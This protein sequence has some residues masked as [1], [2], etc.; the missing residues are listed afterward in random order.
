MIKKTCTIVFLLG[1]FYSF[2]QVGIGTDEPTK[3]LDVNG[4]VRIRNLANN[5]S[6]IVVAEVDGTLALKAHEDINPPKS[7]INSSQSSASQKVTIYDGPCYNPN[8]K[9]SSCSIRFNHY[10]SCAGF[11]NPVSTEIIVVNN[12]NAANG[13]YGSTWSTKFLDH[14]GDDTTPTITQTNSTTRTYQ[15]SGYFE[16]GR[17]QASLITSLSNGRLKIESEKQFM[18]THLIYLISISRYTN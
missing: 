3:E 16:G 17:C 2:S 9:T 6:K 13:Q 14:K 1:S 5:T 15:G 10:T 18:Y 4:D 12:I 7:V 8:D 11:T